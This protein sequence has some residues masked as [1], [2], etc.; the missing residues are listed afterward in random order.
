MKQGLVD[1]FL[2][3]PMTSMYPGESFANFRVKVLDL[4]KFLEQ[5]LASVSVYYAG[6]TPPTTT[7]FE[8]PSR[9]F[10]IDIENLNAARLF[11]LIYPEPTA[12]SA[13]IELGFAIKLGIPLVIITRQRKR[14]PHLVQ[15]LDK[16]RSNVFIFESGESDPFRFLRNDRRII[17]AVASCL[18][19][20]S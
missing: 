2:S 20:N 1:I 3:T 11:F 13:L 12:S 6:R 4:I 18:R 7:K 9:A 15:E 17:R 8:I 14:L 19:R 10:D 5:E 16:N